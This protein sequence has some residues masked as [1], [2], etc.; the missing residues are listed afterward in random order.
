MDRIIETRPER[1]N[2]AP[3]YVVESGVVLTSSEQ[4]DLRP[5]RRWRPGEPCPE[6]LQPNAVAALERHAAVAAAADN[7]APDDWKEAA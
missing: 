5:P 4:L 7:Y 1:K 3:F 2:K 6:G